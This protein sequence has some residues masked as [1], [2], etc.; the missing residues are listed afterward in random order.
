MRGLLGIV[1]VLGL[2][3]AAWAGEVHTRSTAGSWGS[4]SSHSV[5]RASIPNDTG[6]SFW[7]LGEPVAT[8][9]RVVAQVR[10]LQHVDYGGAGVALIDPRATNTASPN[11]RIELSERDDTVGVG[12]WLGNEN[13][14][15]GASRKAG[16]DIALNQWYSLELEV[17]GTH[18]RGSLD[19]VSVFDGDLPEVAKLPS[20][21]VVAPFVIEANAELKVT[22]YRSA[23]PAA[24]DPGTPQV[25]VVAYGHDDTDGSGVYWDTLMPHPSFDDDPQRKGLPNAAWDASY[26]V[27]GGQLCVTIDGQSHTI[28]VMRFSGTPQQTRGEVCEPIGGGGGGHGSKQPAAAIPTSSRPQAEIEREFTRRIREARGPE[29]YARLFPHPEELFLI[30]AGHKL[31]LDPYTRQWLHYDRVHATWEPTGF[32]PGDVRFE[33]IGRRFGV[34]RRKGVSFK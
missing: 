5:M 32:G 17:D 11:V 21:L 4:D 30:V 23:Q 3:Q 24:A 31:V 18:V 7:L 29:D 6:Y 8:P 27:R 10:F 9:I 20:S 16:K 19:G 28:V 14:F 15:P 1:G 33:M 26:D 25:Q 12:G 13:H 34:T 2:V 22:S